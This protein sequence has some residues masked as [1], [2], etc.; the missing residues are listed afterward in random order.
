[1]TDYYPELSTKFEVKKLRAELHKV[2]AHEH[3]T[4]VLLQEISST[5]EFTYD[6]INNCF[7]INLNH[8]DKIDN[9]D[10]NTIDP[11]F[12]KNSPFL[13]HRH[14]GDIK[15]ILNKKKHLILKLSKKNKAEYLFLYDKYIYPKFNNNNTN[16]NNNN[17]NHN[18]NN[19]NNTSNNN[20][21]ITTTDHNSH[22]SINNNFSNITNIS[23]INGI[24]NINNINAINNLNNMNN[25]NNLNAL[26]ALNNISSFNNLG[27]STLNNLSNINSISHL[28]TIS[29]INSLNNVSNS[30]N[31]DSLNSF[32]GINTEPF[33]INS[34]SSSNSIMLTSGT[35]SSVLST[36]ISLSY[37]GTTG[38]FGNDNDYLGSSQSNQCLSKSVVSNYD[39]SSG[40]SSSST[41]ISSNTN[42]TA[43]SVNDSTY[44][45]RTSITSSAGTYGTINIDPFPNDSTLETQLSYPQQTASSNLFF[46]PASNNLNSIQIS[47]QQPFLNP[48][49]QQQQNF[50]LQSQINANNRISGGLEE[51]SQKPSINNNEFSTPILTSNNIITECNLMNNSNSY[52]KRIF[53]NDAKINNSIS[54]KQNKISKPMSYAQ[55]KNQYHL[56]LETFKNYLK[57]DKNNYKIASD[58]VM[59]LIFRKIIPSNLLMKISKEIENNVVFHNFIISNNYSLDEKLN[60]I[61]NYLARTSINDE[62][63]SGKIVNSFCNDNS[64]IND[65]EESKSRNNSFCNA[66]N[67]KQSSLNNK[68]G[69][70]ISEAE[71]GTEIK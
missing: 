13:N 63:N 54:K 23:D 37:D 11:N 36:P 14:I 26:N 34:N 16:H 49:H 53:S 71:T 60:F 51:G 10:Q 3:D 47:P 39:A 18:N 19:Q 1:M 45:N 69:C 30:N 67:I 44:E 20:S 21:N 61:L 4:F 31:I 56:T 12:N 52:Q 29:N 22:N 25:I 46:Q 15:F 24:N 40:N 58:I 43:N 50:L 55:L 27:I 66:E 6:P 35:S 8:F 59:D 38:L 68:V 17:T 57:H 7:T 42:T 5:L 70:I 32:N 41:N 2:I 9:L 28:N 62:S 64:T 48:F 65:T 33:A